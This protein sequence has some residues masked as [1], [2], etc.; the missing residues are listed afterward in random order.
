MCIKDWVIVNQDSQVI[1]ST[2]YASFPE[3]KKKA[4]ELCMSTLKPMAVF[5]LCAVFQMPEPKPVMHMAKL[6][7]ECVVTDNN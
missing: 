6:A 3:A 7:P 5:E 4:E 2:G 1:V